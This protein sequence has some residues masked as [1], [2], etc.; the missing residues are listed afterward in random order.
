MQGFF[1]NVLNPK[2]ALFFLAFVPQFISLDAPYKAL[3]FL[4]LGLVFD[5]NGTLFNIFV[6]W[7]AARTSAGMR[8]GRY[9]SWLNRCIG[10]FFIYLGLRLA[11]VKS[12]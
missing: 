4:F 6:A 3:A 10:G 2:V 8:G 9:A 5:F 7:F 11:F 12:G 1:T